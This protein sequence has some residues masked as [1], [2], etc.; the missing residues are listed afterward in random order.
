M[1]IIDNNNNKTTDKQKPSEDISAAELQVAKT[2]EINEEKPAKRERRQATEEELSNPLH[3]VK[4]VQ[5]LE[6]LI[7]HYGWKYLADRTNI[8]CFKYNPTMK[9]SLGFL[10]KTTWAREFVEDLYLEMVKEKKS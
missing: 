3:G 2:K 7:E 6:S 8:R 10:R 9:S 4:L 1:D 5:L